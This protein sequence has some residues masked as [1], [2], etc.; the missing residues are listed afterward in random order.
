[1]PSPDKYPTQDEWIKKN[2]RLQFSKLARITYS[3][4]AIKQSPRTPGPGEYN[5]SP[6]KKKYKDPL[7]TGIREL[8]LINEAVC[9]GEE[10]PLSFDSKFSLV[11]P[12]SVSPTFKH[13][14]KT[15]D[16]KIVKKDGG[17]SRKI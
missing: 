5:P 6:M 14:S 11:V 2:K 16:T 9:K 17:T 7:P 3:E 12:R 13:Y 1:L 4:L 15:R 10:N 8:G